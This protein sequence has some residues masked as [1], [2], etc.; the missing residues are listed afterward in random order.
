MGPAQFWQLAASSF[1]GITIASTTYF[2]TIDAV[3]PRITALLAI[4]GTALISLP[5]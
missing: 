2:A 4:A 5:G 3:G 1:A